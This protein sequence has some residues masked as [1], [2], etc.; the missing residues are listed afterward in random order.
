[1]TR[2]MRADSI[3]TRRRLQPA[4]T[5]NT[6]SENLSVVSPL[7]TKHITLLHI[8]ISSWKTEDDSGG[9]FKV[10]LLSYWFDFEITVKFGMSPCKLEAD[11]YEASNSEHKVL[12][13]HYLE[14]LN[15]I[16]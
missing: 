2:D 12:I 4:D 5:F 13:S 9:D 16:L 14:I 10:S 3:P 11:Q 1:M 15:I 8:F 6:C 7:I